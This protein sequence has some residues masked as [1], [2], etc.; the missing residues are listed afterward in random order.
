MQMSWY[1]KIV[2]LIPILMSGFLL[3]SADSGKAIIKGSVHDLYSGI[4]LEFANIALFDELDST[5]VGGTVT[6]D[7]G[8]FEIVALSIG[9]YFLKAL[10]IGYDEKTIHSIIITSKRQTVDLGLIQLRLTSVDLED[11]E[12]EADRT[13]VVYKIDR[14]V[15]NIGADLAD[16]GGSAVDA[17]ESV[18]SVKVDIEGNVL[19]RGSSSFTLLVDGRPSVYDG[20]DA[21]KQIPV[22][23]IESIEIITNPSAKYDASGTAGIINVITKKEKRI[24]SSGLINLKPGSFGTILGDFTYNLRTQKL[25]FYLGGNYGFSRLDG[26][27]SSYIELRDGNLTNFMLTEGDR[28]ENSWPAGIDIGLDYEINKQ[29][30]IMIGAY[31]GWYKKRRTEDMTY[32]SWNSDNPE[33]V[34]SKRNWNEVLRNRDYYSVYGDFYHKFRK[35][36]HKLQFS[37][38]YKLGEAEETTESLKFDPDNTVDYGLQTYELNDV[39]FWRANIDY[40]LPIGENKKLEAGYESRSSLEDE[41]YSFQNYESSVGGFLSDFSLTNNTSYLLMLNSAY[42]QFSGEWKNLGYQMGLRGEHTHRTFDHTSGIEPFGLDRFDFFPSI[43]LSYQLPHKQQLLLSYARRISRPTGGKMEPF[44]TWLNLNFKKVGNSNLLPEY[45]DSYELSWM[46]KF[47]S[48]WVSFEGFLKSTTNDIATVQQQ[49]NDSVLLYTYENFGNKY[50]LGTELAFD[51]DIFK[52]WNIDCSSDYYYFNSQG[53]DLDYTREQQ[54]YSW[55]VRMRNNFKPWKLTRIQLGTAYIGPN[56]IAQGES[57]GYFMSF[58]VVRQLFLK[59]NLSITVRLHDLLQTGKQKFNRYGEGF[60]NEMEFIRK[61]PTYHVTIAY[62]FNRM[63]RMK[64]V[65][66]KMLKNTED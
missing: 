26:V 20:P 4:P 60:Y 52:W 5:I 10:F 22:S 55:N 65:E 51:L 31:K 1:R 38:L 49:L 58:I 2:L 27:A 3:F 43:H 15:V 42:T 61:A 54:E 7:K 16:S 36:G 13:S 28:P 24:G 12:I 57:E 40:T 30:S 35:K 66:D 37:V 34:N 32:K 59:N 33:L 45:S 29:N 39:S 9:N 17:L 18:P 62:R 11:I 23:T 44:E 64:K 41:G 56:Y 46:K 19:L 6:N 25:N 63:K 14:K 47:E 48:G 21:L 8:E 53:E 50:S